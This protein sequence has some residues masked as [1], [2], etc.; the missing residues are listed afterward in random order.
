MV[1]GGGSSGCVSSGTCSQTDNLMT[2]S[3]WLCILKKPKSVGIQ[4]LEYMEFKYILCVSNN[5]C[6]GKI[7]RNGKDACYFSRD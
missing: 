7:T 4:F 2:Y 1:S 6:I 3:H 5:I